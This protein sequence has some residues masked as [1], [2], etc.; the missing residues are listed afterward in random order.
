MRKVYLLMVVLDERRLKM[1][2]YK[3]F[4][5]KAPM[6]DVNDAAMLLIDHQ[7][8]L[9]QCINDVDFLRIRDRAIALAEAATLVNMP[10]ITTASVPQGPNGPLI[11]EIHEAAPHAVYVARRGEVNSWD[12]KEF[13]DAV[14][15]TG[16]KT[17]I[18]AGTVTSVCMALPALSAVNEGYRVFAVPDASGTYAPEA[19]IATMMRLTQAGVVITDAGAVLA[20]L[21][22]TWHTP[23]ADAWAQIWGRIF[24]NYRLLLESYA[25]AVEV[26]KTGEPLDNER[27]D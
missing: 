20:E 23:Q 22:R 4:D 7:S 6:I 9:F 25:K 11:P 17:L 5:G 3:N 19:A 26:V 15:A 8:G 21:Q 14:K 27:E 2:L 18:I 24:T 16:K 13:V 12:C 10:V 1:E